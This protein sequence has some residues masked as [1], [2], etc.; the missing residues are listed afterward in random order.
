MNGS[1]QKRFRFQIPYPLFQL[2]DGTR[3]VLHGLRHLS[4]LD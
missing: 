1:N 2:A 4:E 3:L